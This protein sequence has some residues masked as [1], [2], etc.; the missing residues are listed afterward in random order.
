MEDE[1]ECEDNEHKEKKKQEYLL[2]WLV[3][4]FNKCSHFIKNLEEEEYFY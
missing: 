3:N 4:K 2:D 1:W